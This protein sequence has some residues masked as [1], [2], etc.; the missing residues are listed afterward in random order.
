MRSG[1]CRLSLYND[2]GEITLDE[3]Q[4]A[5]DVLA[6][7]EEE[8]ASAGDVQYSYGQRKAKP[9]YD[10]FDLTQSERNLMYY[11]MNEEFRSEKN[12]INENTKWLYADTKGMK[13]FVIYGN[14][15]PNGPTALYASHGK[16]SN[17]RPRLVYFT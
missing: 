13:I 16:K 11:R 7:Q 10:Y 2:R 12:Q 8:D 1:S 9:R 4:D 15:D 17:F 3:Y 14:G 5:W 6:Q